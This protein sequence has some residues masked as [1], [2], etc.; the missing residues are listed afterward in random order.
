MHFIETSSW[1]WWNTGHFVLTSKL[2]LALIFLIERRANCFERKKK[3][4]ESPQCNKY[5]ERLL[6]D[7]V[8]MLIVLP[9][10]K[11]IC[12]DYALKWMQTQ[13]EPLLHIY[14]LS[15]SPPPLPKPKLACLLFSARK[16]QKCL[17]RGGRGKLGSFS[18]FQ[19]LLLHKRWRCRRGQG[20]S[21]NYDGD[22]CKRNGMFQKFA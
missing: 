8:L 2:F 1:R 22:F 6:K 7:K 3:T 21:S 11:K 18:F 5:N 12:I 4:F 10:Q 9:A 19:S 17:W 14:T 13:T 16:L 20:D 15:P